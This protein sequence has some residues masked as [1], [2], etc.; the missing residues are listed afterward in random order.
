[1][2]Y[3]AMAGAMTGA[4]GSLAGASGQQNMSDAQRKLLEQILNE[5]RD[6]PLPDLERIMAEQLGPSAMEGVHSDP[7]QRQAQLDIMDELRDIYSSG[8]LNLEDKAALNEGLNRA[9]VAG[10]ASRQ[11]LASDFAARGQLG[12]GA[13]LAMGNMGAQSAANRANQTALDVGAMGQKRRMDAMG[14]YAGLASDV[15]GQDFGESSARAQAKDA[16]DRWNAASRE[17]AGYY[18]AGLA[19]QQFGNRMTKATGS[20]GAGNNLAA[21][22]GADGRRLAAL[23][24][25]VG[26][27]GANFVNAINSGNSSGGT[28]KRDA[29]GDPYETEPEEWENPWGY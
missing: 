17:K 27:T 29:N 19:Q 9:N 12:S 7:E 24:G 2:D 11:R 8:G 1:M 21:Q 28:T 14:R 15:R 26:R 25:D 23:G 6:I 10:N 22:Y 20:Q 18:N 5:I 13:Q 4:A 3:G 16:A